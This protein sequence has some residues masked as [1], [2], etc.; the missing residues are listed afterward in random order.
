MSHAIFPIVFKINRS[1]E[2]IKRNP[3]KKLE[4]T[5]LMDR[6]KQGRNSQKTVSSKEKGMWKKVS[7]FAHREGWKMICQTGERRD[8]VEGR[9]H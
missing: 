6:E 9:K 2:K 7:G 3:K 5:I 1:W 4:L 8:G